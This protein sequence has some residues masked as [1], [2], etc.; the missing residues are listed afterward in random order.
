MAATKSAP[1]TIQGWHVLTAM[2]LF[3]GV[4]F[5]VNGIFLTAALRTHTGIV[6][7]QPYRI[8]L[9]YN[10]RIE[11][12]ERQK[13]LGWTEKLTLDPSANTLQLELMDQSGGPVS[14]LVIS[15]FVGRPSTE[16]HDIEVSLVE[17][18]KPGIYSAKLDALPTGNWLIQLE[19]IRLHRTTQETVYRIRKRIWLKP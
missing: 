6:S 19:A 14:G 13:N 15:G 5:A 16:Q 11:A 17:T 18:T 3:F 2:L 10:K 4:I 8:G 7:K 9:D 1:F 12:G